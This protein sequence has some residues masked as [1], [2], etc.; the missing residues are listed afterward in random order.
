MQGKSLTIEPSAVFQKNYT[1]KK[2]ENVK[3]LYN[4]NFS[5]LRVT[6]VIIMIST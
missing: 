4:L 1:S 3:M 5:L 2:S 6:K